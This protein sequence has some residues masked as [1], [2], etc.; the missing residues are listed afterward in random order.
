MNFLF[1]FHHL[2][3][4]D[5]VNFENFDDVLIFLTTFPFLWAKLEMTMICTVLEG[6]SL[7]FISTLT[8]FSICNVS[9]VQHSII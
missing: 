9:Y 4:V 5:Y 1:L 8:Q 7:L 2:N 3:Y 6:F